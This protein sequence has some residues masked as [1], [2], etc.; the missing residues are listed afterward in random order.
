VDSLPHASG[1]K[2]RPAWGGRPKLYP[3]HTGA[4]R[5]RGSLAPGTPV[6]P[7]AGTVFL[8]LDRPPRFFRG[9][10]PPPRGGGW[11][12]A[13]EAGPPPR[14]RGACSFC[15]HLGHWVWECPAQSPQVRAHG[16]AL[17]E[18]VAAHRNGRGPAPPAP[19]PLG[20]GQPVPPVPPAGATNGTVPPG[21]APFVHAVETDDRAYPDAAGDE[22]ESSSEKWAEG[23]D[24]AG[25][26]DGRTCHAQGNE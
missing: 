14:R 20:A 17:G 1:W 26:G 16:R 9:G 19:L 22:G 6:P 10:A 8:H 21:T 23:A 2:Q 12:E 7:R 18:A 3:V 11:G 24:G 4:G 5:G 15:G 25:H 13:P